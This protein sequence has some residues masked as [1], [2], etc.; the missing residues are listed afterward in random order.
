[1]SKYVK[2]SMYTFDASI[3]RVEAG[4]THLV[5]DEKA[6]RWIAAGI[7]TAADGPAPTPPPPE[8]EPEPEADE[9]EDEETD[10][11]L[12][13]EAKKLSESGDSQRTIADKLGISRATVRRLLAA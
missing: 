3:G 5:D 1:V 9:G 13:A 2:A 7:A 11:E 8:P 12:E 6:D 4:S 10:E